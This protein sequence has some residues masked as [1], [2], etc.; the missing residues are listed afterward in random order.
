MF[1]VVWRSLRIILPRLAN[2]NI[3]SHILGI[4]WQHSQNLYGRELKIHTAWS[5]WGPVHTAVCTTGNT[6]NALRDIVI[7]TRNRLGFGLGSA[8]V[9][10]F[11]M[12]KGEGKTRPC[13]IF[14]PCLIH[15]RRSRKRKLGEVLD[16]LLTNYSQSSNGLKA[17]PL[18]TLRR[19][20]GSAHRCSPSAKIRAAFAQD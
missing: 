19:A 15:I 4:Y 13:K 14:K 10:I 3:I 17:D 1:P 12:S 18:C 11:A 2:D 9:R 6:G 16:K 5:F 7:K 8:L 20:R